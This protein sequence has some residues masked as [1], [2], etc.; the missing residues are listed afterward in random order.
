MVLGLLLLVARQMAQLLLLVVWVPAMTYWQ[1]SHLRGRPWH[2]AGCSR[3]VPGGCFPRAAWCHTMDS[4]CLQLGLGASAEWMSLWFPRGLVLTP[5]TE[6]L[7]Q[8]LAF[9]QANSRS[10]R[11]PISPCPSRSPPPPVTAAP[12]CTQA[13]GLIESWLSNVEA[14]MRLT[15]KALAKKALKD[16]SASRRPAWSLAQPAQLALLAANIHWCQVR[17][18]SLPGCQG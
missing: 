18:G 14:H 4:T 8:V 12:L 15:L 2:L 3:W 6:K 17:A 1:C 9:K 13:R 7:R 11:N 10:Q 16:Y 5:G